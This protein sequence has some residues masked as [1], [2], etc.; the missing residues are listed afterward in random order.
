[1]TL[2]NGFQAIEGRG[3]RLGFRNLF[4]KENRKWWSSSRWWL[5]ALI[6]L[7]IL[8]G[9]VFMAL[10]IIPGLTT[11]EGQPALEQD[12]VEGA[13][14]GFF[15]IGA[16]ALALGVTILMQDE[17]IGEVQA[18]TAEWVLSKPVSRKA[19]I[20]SKLAAHTLGMLV[21]M[22]GI[23]GAAAYLMISAFS[24]EP[25]P[26]ASF[27]SGVGILTIHTFFYLALALMLG[28]LV[29]RRE[30][31]LAVALV[32]LLGGSFI[33]NLL[34]SAALVTPWFLSDVSG[35][36]AMGMELP[37]ELL[38]PVLAATLWSIIF[39]VVSL[40]VFDRLEF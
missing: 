5:Q 19:F 33:R 37:V 39:V 17:V 4:S 40:R 13:V 11:P 20:L 1:M 16:I 18:G 21:V 29:N 25:Y 31:V 28:V 14:Q 24:G 2:E 34:P 15:G 7:A 26:P 3:W 38:I 8:V 23:P 10:F 35:L 9:F 36:A 27:L 30:L 12:L 32:S 6:W 22:I